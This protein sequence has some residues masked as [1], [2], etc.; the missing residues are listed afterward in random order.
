LKLNGKILCLATLAAALFCGGCGGIHASRSVSPLDFF[1]PGIGSFLY[2][3]TPAAPVP[4]A[5]PG[6]LFAQAN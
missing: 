1:M 5:K 6:D 4:P 2:A 3:P